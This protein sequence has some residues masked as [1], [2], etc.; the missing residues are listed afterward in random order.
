M[1]ALLKFLTTIPAS[2]KF[3]GSKIN[4]NIVSYGE[5]QKY[6]HI[7]DLFVDDSFIL[8]Y[9]GNLISMGHWCCA[10]RRGTTISYFDSY[11]EKPDPK[12]YIGNKY[13]HLSRL[14]YFCD[15]DLEYSE[16][17]Y[18]KG[19]SVTCGYH[20]IVRIL[21]KHEPLK[22]YQIFMDQFKNDD[23]VVAAISFA[24]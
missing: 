4:T 17:D 8:L 16:Y 12:E 1:S 15:Y 6:R 13:P 10:V 7:D 3:I 19:K 5:L 9:E 22:S 20:C 21:F 14:L 23:E 18:Q 11:G 24:L 2:D